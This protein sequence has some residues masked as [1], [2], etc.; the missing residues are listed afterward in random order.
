[1]KPILVPLALLALSACGGGSST[2]VQSQPTA[3]EQT[4]EAAANLTGQQGS[5]A[6]NEVANIEEEIVAEIEQA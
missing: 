6:E 3:E 4:E 5:D 1:M 2:P